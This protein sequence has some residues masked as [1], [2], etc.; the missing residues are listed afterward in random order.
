MI[1]APPGPDSRISEALGSDLE[2]PDVNRGHRIG[3]R[4]D[5]C[6]RRPRT[7]TT[8]SGQPARNERRHRRRRGAPY[9]R[10]G[11]AHERSPSDTFRTV[12]AAPSGP[13]P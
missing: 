3:E 11:D 10:D 1:G 7:A 8:R 4:L 9:R 5:R 12:R 2:N 6:T 13:N